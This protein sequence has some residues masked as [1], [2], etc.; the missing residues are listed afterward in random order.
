MH[1]FLYTLNDVAPV[2]PRARQSLGQRAVAPRVEVL[3]RELLQLSI[4]L[5]QPQ[6]VGDGRVD[7]ERLPS[8]ALT[9]VGRHGQHG[10]HVVQPV[11]QLDENDAHVTRHRQQHFA[12][13][14]SLVLLASAEPQTFKLG[15]PVHQFGCSRTKFFNQFDLGDTLVFNR[16]MH[17]R[18][19]DGL[20]VKAP[21]GTQARHGDG[22]GDVG[23]ATGAELPQV[24]FISELVGLSYQAHVGLGQVGQF[25]DQR[26]KGRG[27]D[28]RR[29]Q[30]CLARALQALQRGGQ[31]FGGQ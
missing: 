29:G 5:I 16:V 10:A 9:L 28:G 30:R 23:Q 11:G 20:R 27:L 18:G 19:H 2:T 21:V 25:V 13:R 24:G 7:V 26:R 31:Q 12:K 4:D 6:A 14:L 3:K 17:Q 1:V 8:D 22:V 15:Q